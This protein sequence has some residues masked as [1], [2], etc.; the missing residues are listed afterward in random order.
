MLSAEQ[1]KR[2]L[3]QVKQQHQHDQTLLMQKKL[4]QRL[5][6]TMLAATILLTSI[7]CYAYW[8]LTRANK[9]LADKN[10]QLDY[11]STHD[12]LTKVFNRR[13]F[14]DFITP[15]L[16][17]KAEALLLLLDIDHFKKV[18]DHYGHQ[19]GDEVLK[20]VSQ[21]LSSRLRE[22]DC[23]IRWGGEE[24]LIFID[25][26]VNEQ[27]SELI[28]RRLLQEIAGTPIKLAQQDITVT[29]SIGFSVVKLTSLPELE[30][31]LDT[32]DS[33]LYHAKNNGR[34]QAAGFWQQGAEMNVLVN[35][36]SPA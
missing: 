3:S 25:N 33:L 31:Q 17:S 21:R 10:R 29:V 16:A 18:N 34:N 36:H 1:Q 35:H 24:F 23:I 11:E 7:S 32:I 14:S 13:Y 6:L 15:R 12:P 27:Q 2:E 4:E 5:T 8:R 19:A 9:Q 26:P 20:I 22:G 30:Q 28:I